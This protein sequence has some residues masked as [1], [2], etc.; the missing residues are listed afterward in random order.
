MRHHGRATISYDGK[1]LSP[2]PG[3]TL[4]LGGVSRTAEPLDDGSVGFSETTAAPELNCS[5]PLTAALDI[6][7]LRNMTGANVVFES[8]TGKGWVIRDAFTVDA[9]TVG[10]DVN[11]KISGQPAV[12]L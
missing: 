5:V 6:E 10:A 7:S 3:A 4:N 11:L 9:V 8:D 2:K 12:A 1:R